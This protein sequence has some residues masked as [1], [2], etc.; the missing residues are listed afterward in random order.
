MLK[1]LLRYLVNTI[2]FVVIFSIPTIFIVGYAVFQYGTKPNAL[3][4]FGPILGLLIAY[5]LVKRINKSNLW[6]SLF[7]KTDTFEEE[8]KKS[9]ID[10]RKLDETK[11][12][13]DLDFKWKM[14]EWNKNYKY[15]KLI[16]VLII[17]LSTVGIVLFLYFQLEEKLD[18]TK[19]PIIF[20][21]KVLNEFKDFNFLIEKVKQDIDFINSREYFNVSGLLKKEEVF[22]KKFSKVSVGMEFDNKDIISFYSDFPMTKVQEQDLEYFLYTEIQLLYL[23]ASVNTINQALMLE[24]N[25]YYLYYARASTGLQIHYIY[26]RINNYKDSYTKKWKELP[27]NITKSI[28]NPFLNQDRTTTY[29]KLCV[30]DL[31]LAVKLLNEVDQVEYKG[32][33][34]GD[35]YSDISYFYGYN[36][37]SDK[38]C[39]YAKRACDYGECQEVKIACK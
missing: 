27:Q 6:S 3:S 36:G 22:S 19:E 11:V 25:N 39:L 31:E 29:W 10:E 13:T 34:L 37:D 23:N 26:E 15:L 2:L 1:K 20:E 16:S 4:A 35:L 14:H 8:V 17:T 7:D 12:M 9:V 18:D 21:A 33:G 32:V 28:N 30:M 5:I 24:P 38:A